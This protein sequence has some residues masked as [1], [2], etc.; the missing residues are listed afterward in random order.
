MSQTKA[1]LLN[2]ETFPQKLQAYS[3]TYN[4]TTISSG[5]LAINLNLGTIFNVNLN[6][7]IT[8]ITVSN[9][10]ATSANSFT[11]FLTADGT[12]RTVSWT[13]NGTAVKW[14][15]SLS[16]TPTSTNG[17]VDI[18][19]FSTNNGGTTWYGFIGGQNF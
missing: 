14:P 1:Q 16:P 4:S 11:L 13:I 8:S 5:V 7:N 15:S 19:S 9:I 3:E 6:A 10:D 2:L 12:Q 17:K 18:F